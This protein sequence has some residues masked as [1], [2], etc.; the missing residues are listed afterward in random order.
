[1]IGIEIGKVIFF[2]V[3]GYFF[4]YFFESRV[5]CYICVINIVDGRRL[6]GNMYFW[7]DMYG[8]CFFVVVWVYF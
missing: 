5:V 3:L 1:M 7:I 2:N 4:C 6:F 8:F